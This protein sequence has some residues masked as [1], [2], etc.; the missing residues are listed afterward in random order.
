MSYT[1]SEL[2]KEAAP[3]SGMKGQSVPNVMW[4]GSAKASRLGSAE[5]LD[6]AAVSK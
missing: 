2:V 6:D 1:S 4:V 3:L 5:G